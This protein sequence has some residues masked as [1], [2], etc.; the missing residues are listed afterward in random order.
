MD[1]KPSQVGEVTHIYKKIGVAIIKF[2]K[3][4]KSG[5]TIRIEGHKG[6]HE[7]IIDS[8]QIDHEKVKEVKKGDVAGVKVDENVC[9][10]DKVYLV[11]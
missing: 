1:K 7:Q 6:S 8:M 2:S 5:M 9:E 4:V 3:S 10:G 11:E